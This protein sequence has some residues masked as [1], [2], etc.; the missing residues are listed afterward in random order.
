MNA[1][2][3]IRHI[4]WALLALLFMLAAGAAA[5]L[6]ASQFHAGAVADLARAIEARGEAQ[7]KLFRARDEEQELRATAARFQELD[8]RGI[9]GDER[10]LDWVEQIRR[11]RER[12][13][14]FDL[15]YE[16]APQQPLDGATQI[17]AY[18]FM[19]SQMRLTLQLLHEDDLLGFLGDL[20][21]QVPAYLRT[22]RCTVDRLPAP[23]APAPVASPQ[24]RA[25][26]ELQWITIRTPAGGAGAE[27]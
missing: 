20:S 24:L 1:G 2:L 4:R 10:R 22:R 5:V 6:Y 23:P 15:Q 26:C 12:R 11:I 13:K 9:V 25:E 8:Q 16:I 7:K 14:L 21:A 3:I 27:S 17:G 18:R 19:A